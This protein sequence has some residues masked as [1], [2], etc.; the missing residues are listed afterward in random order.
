MKTTVA[1]TINLL[2]HN[3][4]K[5]EVQLPD[6]ELKCSASGG[7]LAWGPRGGHPFFTVGAL[8]PQHAHT[9]GCC[10]DTT[11]RHCRAGKTPQGQHSHLPGQPSPQKMHHPRLCCTHLPVRCCHSPGAATALRGPEDKQAGPGNDLTT[12]QAPSERPGPP[13]CHPSKSAGA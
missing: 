8:S 6:N 1:L 10:G 12:G 9:L 11:R 2:M 3:A 7:G 5:A 13:G 4:N